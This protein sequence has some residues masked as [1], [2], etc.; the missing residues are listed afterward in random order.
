MKKQSTRIHIK[1]PIEQEF[2][3]MQQSLISARGKPLS[4]TKRLYGF[5]FRIA[6][7]ALGYDTQTYAHHADHCAYLSNFLF[8]RF[9]EQI[10]D[11]DAICDLHKNILPPET[12]GSFIF[13][14]EQK[15]LTINRGKYRSIDTYKLTVDGV[16]VDFL[17]HA[18]I[19]DALVSAIETYHNSKKTI[20]DIVQ[21][22]LEFNAIHPFMD[23]NGKVERILLD[24]LLLANN[25]YPSLLHKAYG[26]YY[27]EI[28]QTCNNYIL[29]NKTKAID[30]F[31]EILLY[32][33][34]KVHYFGGQK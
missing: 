32:K 6:E 15:A 5:L 22:Y 3:K 13:A 18:N 11:A 34:Y 33:C 16:G 4:D 31:M 30:V 2:V 10:F 23:G 9:I 26:E 19:S 24:T 17:H 1:Y 12:Q 7:V 20:R 28:V 27:S 25:F 29:Y 14:D 8:L 21:F